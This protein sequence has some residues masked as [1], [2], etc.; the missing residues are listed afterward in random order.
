MALRKK[1]IAGVQPTGRERAIEAAGEIIVNY[2]EQWQEQGYLVV[3][4]TFDVGR[5]QRLYEVCESAFAQWRE[6]SSEDSEPFGYC[7]GPTAW[8]LIHLNHPKY[9]RQYSESL[10]LLLDAVA[11]PLAMQITRDI[12]QEA[13]MFMQAN[14]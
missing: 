7:Y 4:G 13:P 12:F 5:V 2:R 8:T 6:E 1:P 14:Y 9:H 10:P 3:R 11:E